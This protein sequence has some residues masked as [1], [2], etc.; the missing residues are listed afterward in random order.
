MMTRMF[1]CLFAATIGFTNHDASFADDPRDQGQ[2]SAITVPTP[3]DV[4][5]KMLDLV[6]VSKADVVYDLGCGDGRIVVTAS[7]KYGC[8]AVGFDI[9]PLKIKQSRERVKKEGVGALVRIEQKDIF[10]VDLTPASV[11]TLYLLPEMNDRLVPQLKKM[12]DGS[13]IVCHDFPIEAFR[14][15]QLVTFKSQEDGA[16]HDIYVYRLPLKSRE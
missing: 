11:I 2:E 7:A 10:T 16:P 12:K 1:L 6:N 14:H 15:E 5:M 3:N 8:H 4:V 9:N 13:R